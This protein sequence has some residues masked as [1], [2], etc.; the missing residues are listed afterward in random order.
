MQGTRR[1]VTEQGGIFTSY[2]CDNIKRKMQLVEILANTHENVDEYF[3]MKDK[4]SQQLPEFHSCVGPIYFNGKFFRNFDE[5]I[6]LMI[7]FIFVIGIPDRYVIQPS[8]ADQESQNNIL[9]RFHSDL[10]EAFQNE[11]VLTQ[12]AILLRVK[13]I[14]SQ[15]TQNSIDCNKKSKAAASVLVAALEKKVDDCPEIFDI[16]LA[17]MKHIEKLRGLVMMMKGEEAVSEDTAETSG[18]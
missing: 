17:E 6:L 2:S 8:E 9:K 10:L 12:L 5:L 4:P 13:G 3:K 18:E 7:F 15:E 16:I 14:L 11:T 1:M